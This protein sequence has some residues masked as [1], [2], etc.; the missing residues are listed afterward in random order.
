MSL[1]VY[2]LAKTL[3]DLVQLIFQF[4]LDCDCYESL[5]FRLL[6]LPPLVRKLMM[7]EGVAP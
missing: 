2:L 7:G 5:G 4:F 6:S 1:V 3:K